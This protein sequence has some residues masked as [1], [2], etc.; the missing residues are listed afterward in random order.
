V[1][2]RQQHSIIS[3]LLFAPALIVILITDLSSYQRVVAIHT[4]SSDWKRIIIIIIVIVITCIDG[5]YGND[6]GAT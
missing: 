3:R 2:P 5:D 6:H 4:W 1:V